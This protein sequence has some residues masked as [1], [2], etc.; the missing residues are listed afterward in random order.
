M[1][2]INYTLSQVTINHIA[3]PKNWTGPG[4]LGGDPGL[5]LTVDA[6]TPKDGYVKTGQVDSARTDMLWGTYRASMKLTATNG[7][8]AAFFWVWIQSC[9]ICWELLVLMTSIVF[10]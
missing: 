3:D 2:G 7:T 10:R 6:G 4:E 1:I 9:W 5:R 8:C